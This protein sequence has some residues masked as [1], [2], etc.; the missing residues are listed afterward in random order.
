MVL[1]TSQNHGVGLSCWIWVTNG[2]DPYY[3]DMVYDKNHFKLDYTSILCMYNNFKHLPM[4]WMAIWMHWFFIKA[5]SWVQAEIAESGYQLGTNY[6]TTTMTWMRPGTSSDWI[7]V[8]YYIYMK[9]LSTFWCSGWSYG[10][11]LTSSKPW[12]WAVMVKFW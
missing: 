12:A 9:C 7:T 8:P 11:I 1:L 3:Y 10:C 5:I 4:Q 2:Y 6:T